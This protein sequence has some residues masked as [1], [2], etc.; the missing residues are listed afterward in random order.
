MGKTIRSNN[1]EEAHNKQHRNYT[2]IDMQEVCKSGGPMR[3]RRARRMKD[4][5]R[6]R[7]DRDQ[8]N[9]S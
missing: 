7:E 2:A 3:D 6:S 1:S 4:T 8:D 9:Y 5:R